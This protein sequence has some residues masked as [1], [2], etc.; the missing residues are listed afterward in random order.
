[1]AQPTI[2]MRAALTALLAAGALAPVALAQE[3]KDGATTASATTATSGSKAVLKPVRK[4]EKQVIALQPIKKGEAT[5]TPTPEPTKTPTA[6]KTPAEK[7]TTPREAT[8]P[9]E[10]PK[11]RQPEIVE[12]AVTPKASEPGPVDSEIPRSAEPETPPRRELPAETTELPAEVDEPAHEAIDLPEPPKP[13]PAREPRE[14]APAPR[15]EADEPPRATPA[16]PAIAA[17]LDAPASAQARDTLDTLLKNNLDHW[18]ATEMLLRIGAI[19]LEINQPDRARMAYEAAEGYTH[20][21]DDKRLARIGLARAEALSGNFRGSAAKWAALRAEA[22]DPALEQTALAAEGLALAAD[23]D[24]AQAEQLWS[25][26]AQSA[27]KAPAAALLGRGLSA[28]L[29]GKPEEARTRL[30]ELVAQWPDA[31]EAM[32]AIERL[33]DLDRALLPKP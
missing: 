10:D 7:S 13:Q 1:M 2:W 6:T 31:P 24:M 23:N 33:T 26:A 32:L 14:S 19:S 11:P 17:A 16:D 3:S 5:P 22:Q 25:E 30:R 9:A 29:Q 15:G 20:N 12:P 21:P 27:G 8:R 28:E 18:R 4:A